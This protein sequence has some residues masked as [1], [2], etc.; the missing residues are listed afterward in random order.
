VF[1]T[2]SVKQKSFTTSVGEPEILYQ[3]ACTSIVYSTPFSC[4]L[5]DKTRACAA[6]RIGSRPTQEDRFVFVERLDDDKIGGVLLGV[7]D[8]TV[9][10]FA[11]ETV[12]KII[13][14]NLLK[15]QNWK[16]FCECGDDLFLQAAVRDM[17]RES[18]AELISLCKIAGKNY[19]S[20]TA[21]VVIYVTGK[22]VVSHLGDSRACLVHQNGENHWGEFL[23]TDHRPDALDERSRI[24]KNGG[25]VVYLQ[26]HNAKPFIR[27]GDFTVRKVQGDQPM[28]LQYSR[29]FGG[30]DLKSYGL[31]SEPDIRIISVETGFVGIVI[32]SDGLWDALSANSV[33]EIVVHNS[34]K[35]EICDILVDRAI[36]LQ[37]SAFIQSD[38]VTAMCIIF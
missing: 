13:V 32:A 25:S 7:F 21:V 33:A 38:N 16:K 11:S 5:S 12:H 31:S 17:Y 1:V 9:G 26:N 19:S 4:K 2:S 10:D 14:V 22:I 6:T 27:G 8:G 29:A 35:S 15:S 18:D 28:Q 34:T 30:K 24:E 36:A 3:M 20:T 23:T 37:A